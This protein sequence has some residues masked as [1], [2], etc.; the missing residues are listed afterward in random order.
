MQS[1][2][3]QQPRQPPAVIT[4]EPPSRI[5]RWPFPRFAPKNLRINK[6]PVRPSHPGSCV[7][8]SGLLDAPLVAAVSVVLVLSRGRP[9]IRFCPAAAFTKRDCLPSDPQRPGGGP[10]C[11]RS[12]PAPSHC[13]ITGRRDRPNDGRSRRSGQPTSAPR[14]LP[15]RRH[16][17][18]VLEI[19]LQVGDFSTLSRSQRHMAA[20][21]FLPIA[22]L[23]GVCKACG[24]GLSPLPDAKAEAQLPCAGPHDLPR[25]LRDEAAGGDRLSVGLPPLGRVP[26][27]PGGCSPAA[28]GG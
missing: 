26:R 5:R 17:H 20:E 1:Q 4:E 15:H 3:H 23:A 21:D 11:P 7:A 27:A 6:L 2:G 8:A 14:P 25:L 22:R 12:R 16:K 10:S 28:T 9:E 24:D 18:E 13:Q 19:F